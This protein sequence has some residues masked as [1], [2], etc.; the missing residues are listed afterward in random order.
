LTTESSL[1]PTLAF[2][3]DRCLELYVAGE[4]ASLS[5]ELL[6]VLDAARALDFSALDD[7]AR[8]FIDLY[9]QS[10]L[11]LFC[12]PDYVPG[13]EDAAR[14]LDHNETI[15]DLAA[16]SSFG[17]TDGAL[18]ILMTQQDNLLKLLALY[19]P[20]NTVWLDRPGLFAANPAWASRWWFAFVGRYLGKVATSNVV[21]HL[22]EH[23][24][25]P[26]EA[27]A[28]ASLDMTNAYFAVSYVD[29]R[30]ER[31]VHARVHD[32]VRRDW[33]AS[34]P[35]RNRPNPRKAA[36]VSAFWF[37]PSVVYRTLARFVEGLAQDFELTLVDL[38]E[39]RFVAK[40]SLFREVVRVGCGNGTIDLRTL[41]DNDFA[42]VYFP[43]V[44][45]S[46]LSLFLANLRL[47][48]VQIAGLGHSVS[49]YG[50]EIDYFVSGRDAEPDRPER[51]YSERLV[52]LPGIGLAPMRCERIPP[53]RDRPTDHVLI[54]C[55][56]YAQK[57]NWEMLRV[58]RR[59]R[60]KAAR[61]VQFQ[62]FP[63]SAIGNLGRIPFAEAVRNVL[64]DGAA[65][66]HPPLPDGLYRERFGNGHFTIDSFPFGG[67]NTAVD[68]LLSGS[69]FV[70]WEGD[71]VYNRFAA[72]MLRAAGLGELIAADGEAYS[73]IVLRLIADED[74]RA[75]V[76]RRV[77]NADLERVVFRDDAVAAFRRAVRLLVEQHDPLREGRTPRVFE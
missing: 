50:A 57:T 25:D 38:S 33:A 54:N 12:R 67:C 5:A 11:Y 1:T 49:T 51:L 27:L 21:A 29:P 64:G 19:S 58:L 41:Q 42:L 10:L 48:P 71:R 6:A 4:H 74:Y 56:W 3:A 8:A 34:V 69:P 16:L 37:E 9:V 75:E 47:A 65:I 73:A 72:A 20:R 15:S 14:F 18:R 39:P 59:I 68:A 23:F 66:I 13:G 2:D 28:G 44:G 46:P 26:P 43:D 45:M 70:T 30:L 77:A 17:T 32:I 62:F 22:R 7:A 55:P 40:T 36:V 76:E 24:R 35:I 63:G 53:R 52:L 60:E 61:P 31:R